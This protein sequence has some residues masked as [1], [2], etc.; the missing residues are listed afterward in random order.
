MADGAKFF[1]YDKLDN[2]HVEVSFAILAKLSAGTTEQTQLARQKVKQFIGKPYYLLSDNQRKILKPIVRAANHLVRSVLYHTVDHSVQRSIY[3]DYPLASFAKGDTV[4]LIGAGWNEPESIK[5]LCTIRDKHAIRIVQHINDILPIYQ[6]HLFVDYLSKIFMSYMEIVIK[7]ADIITVISEATKRD[8][9]IFCKEQKAVQ[10]V[11]KV[12]RLGEDVPVTRPVNPE[13]IR[14]S[15]KFILSVGTFEIRKNYILLYQAAKLAQLEGRDFPDIVIAGRKGWLT[16][17]LTYVIDKDPFTR[18]HIR[19]LQNLSDEE[20]D[21][22]YGHCMFT[23]FPSLCEGWGLPVV[24]SLQHGK[25]C[26]ASSVSSM[27]EIGNGM[28][29]YFSPYD[30][31]SIM[32][33]V[34]T[35]SSGAYK[36]KN[37]IVQNSY[38]VYSWDDSYTSFKDAVS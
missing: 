27:L 22:L 26:I 2:R 37:R 19:W 36:E 5:L 15:D 29:D 20:I 17:D 14:S 9:V 33:K 4:V 1:I 23:V 13:G 8:L 7:N 3:R 34:L 21:W 28:V 25:L 6:P 38:E 24:E 30:A 31:R 35:Y 16:E 10:P 11:I 18:G 12:V 32:E